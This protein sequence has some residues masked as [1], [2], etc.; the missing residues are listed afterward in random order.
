MSRHLAEDDKEPQRLKKMEHIQAYSSLVN[1][2]AQILLN[3]SGEW[4][5]E[6]GRMVHQ[7]GNTAQR[8]NTRQVKLRAI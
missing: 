3:R 8:Y 4:R 2:E 7:N 6:M 5:L 1:N